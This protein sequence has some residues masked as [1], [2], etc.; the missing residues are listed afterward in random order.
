[1]NYAELSQAI[2]DFLQDDETSFQ[3]NI[4]LFIRLGERRIYTTLKLPA[5]REN[6]TGTTT[7]GNRFLSLPSDT[8]SVL[9]LQITGGSGVTVLVQKDM[10]FIREA[11]PDPTS[12]GTPVLYGIYDE[13]TALLGP[14]PDAAYTIEMSYHRV[15]DSIVTAST[16][17]LGDN[18]DRLLLY[19]SLAE[20]Y[21]YMKGDE[22]LIATY[23]RG[24]REEL[25]K[26]SVV[27]RGGA[28]AGDE[29]RQGAS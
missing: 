9:S 28:Y 12:T 3:G 22:D 18:F 25:E 6:V 14:T 2:S 11:Y 29:Y 4:D 5:A 20:G 19:A 23:E 8:L 1:M 16:T 24:Y 26:A 13:D 10:D 17:W 15:P 27:L 7:S 21:T